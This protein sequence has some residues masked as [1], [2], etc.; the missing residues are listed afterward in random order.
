MKMFKLFFLSLLGIVS[1]LSS[2]KAAVIDLKI[3]QSGWGSQKKD[4]KKAM[5]IIDA[6]NDGDLDKYYSG[7]NVDK[8]SLGYL[9]FRGIKMDLHFSGALVAGGDGK[10]EVSIPSIGYHKVY[11]AT[12]SEKSLKSAFKQ[13]KEDLKKNKDGLLKKVVKAAIK[14]TP[15]DAIAGN[16]SS[17]LSQM[18]MLST[19]NGVLSTT[20]MA[21]SYISTSNGSGYIMLSPSAS[22]HEVKMGG[23]STQI[24]QYSLPLG[25]TFKFDN[26]WAFG[27]DMPISYTD[28][29]G[30]KTY[31]GQMGLSLQ[32]PLHTSK[33][34]SKVVYLESK[35]IKDSKK[36]EN[37]VI[38]DRPGFEAWHLIP[39]VRF[40]GTVSKDLLS[41]GALYMGSLTSKMV[42]NFTNRFGFDLIN[43]ASK[44]KSYDLEVNGYEF[45]YD[46]DS[47]IFRNGI[48][49]RTGLSQNFDL[50]LYFYDTRFS[51]KTKMYIDR[52][53]EVGFKLTKPFN[54]NWKMLGFITGWDFEATYI[55]GPHYKAYKAGFGLLF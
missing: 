7:F 11:S 45:E 19:S 53:E 34:K 18:A 28:T 38:Q 40:G 46:I 37:E 25:Y 26:D 12:D 41:G 47:N 5:D 15:Y 20:S 43:M 22:N 52:N 23:K 35:D 29:E 49:V 21:S 55:T 31:T 48:N 8:E 36:Q 39:S 1:F 30:S 42:F 54:N 4:F 44:A 27:F 13:F 50:D 16:P 32:I 10:L 17:L 24:K 3:E 33:A 14:N 9:N 2:A 6:Y 51:G